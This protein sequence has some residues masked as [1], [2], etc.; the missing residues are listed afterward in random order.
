MEK[1][2][3]RI[4]AIATHFKYQTQWEAMVD[5]SWKDIQCGTWMDI[6]KDGEESYSVQADEDKLSCEQGKL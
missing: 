6:L 5:G 1:Q 4:F 3:R 2:A